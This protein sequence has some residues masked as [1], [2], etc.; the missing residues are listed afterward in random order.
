MIP[1]R[2]TRERIYVKVSSEFDKTGYM[3]PTA[4]TWDDGRVFKI[5][6]VRDF[7]PA[8]TVG[9]NFP[10]DCYTV[11]INGMEKHLFFEHSDPSFKS[12][13]GRWFVERTGT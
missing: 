11:V 3:Q 4:I 7:R 12:R 8:G 9:L 13:V 1:K 5:E 2:T 6:T 10:G